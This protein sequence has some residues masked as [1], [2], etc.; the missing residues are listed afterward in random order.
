MPCCA[1]SDCTNHS[2]KSKESGISFHRFLVGKI[3]IKQRLYACKSTDNFCISYAW[4]SSIHFGETV[5]VYDLKSELFNLKSK[6]ALKQASVSSMKMPNSA[7]V[8]NDSRRQERVEKQ[9]R[10]KEINCLLNENESNNNQ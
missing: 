5:Y 6:R 3:T 10:M 1:I 2:R 7:F 9:I 4:I 8:I